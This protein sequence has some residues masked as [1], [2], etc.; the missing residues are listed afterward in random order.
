MYGEP[1]SEL[2]KDARSLQRRLPGCDEEQP[3]AKTGRTSLHG[4]LHLL[5]QAGVI[6]QELLKLI[7]YKQSARQL[8]GMFGL[9]PEHVIHRIQEIAIRD[10]LS[11]G[12][13]ISEKLAHL[14]RTASEPRH[15]LQNGVSKNR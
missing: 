3:G 11:V 2:L 7:E 8:V 4:I 10:L 12:V 5:R 15:N 14:E 6:T 1:V 9:K 13:L